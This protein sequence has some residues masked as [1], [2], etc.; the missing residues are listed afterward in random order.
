MARVIELHCNDRSSILVV[1]N[2]YFLARDK[3]MNYG[4]FF[5]DN[6]LYYAKV[7]AS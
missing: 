1:V 3:I 4:G 2:I 5:A 7:T 6:T